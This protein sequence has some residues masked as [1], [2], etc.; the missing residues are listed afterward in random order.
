MFEATSTRFIKALFVVLLLGGGLGVVAMNVLDPER[1]AR[2]ELLE[3]DHARMQALL[4]HTERENRSLEA[5]LRSLEEGVAGWYD[6]ARRD[7][8]MIRDGE[9]VFRFPV[10]TRAASAKP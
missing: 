5:E 10:A 6:V 7:H 4:T 3:Q 2:L 1:S 9:V 8:G